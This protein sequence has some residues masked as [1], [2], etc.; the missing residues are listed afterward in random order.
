MRSL[1]TLVAAG[2]A[3]GALVTLA[4]A[5]AQACSVCGCG[6][7]L[8]SSSDPLASTGALRLQLDAELLRVDA[9]TDGVPGATDQLTQ[10]SY[11]LNAAWRPVEPLT[12]A[13]TLPLVSKRIR[14]VGAGLD[15]VTSDLTGL[16]DAE[17]TGRLRVWRSIREDAPELQELA[18]SAG[19]AMPTGSHRARDAAGAL[20]DPHGQLG[21]GGWGPFAGLHYRVEQGDWLGFASLAVRYRTE[22]SYFDGTRYKFGDALLWSVHG[23]YLLGHRVALDLGL[24]G[25]AAAA[26][27]M[28]DPDGTVTPRVGNT[29]GTVWS[30]APGVY[31]DVAA[32]IW[33]FARGQV[34]VVQRL[35]GEQDV[36]PTVTVGVQYL[37]F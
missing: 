37:V 19:T 21:T 35:R 23:Q 4:P 8:A 16:G 9:G 11:R 30:V 34:P 5:P 2:L 25:R 7:P 17:V 1:R 31:A 13:A 32:G 18:V 33:L 3:A 24:D 12:L 6:D 36:K 10:R 28:V 14:T 15:Q 22:A 20:V 27:R 26:D 29:G